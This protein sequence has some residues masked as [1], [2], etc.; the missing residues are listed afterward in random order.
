MLRRSIVRVLVALVPVVSAS[1]FITSTPNFEPPA[2]TAPLLIARDASPPLG[3]VVVLPPTEHITLTASVISQD[4]VPVQVAIYIDYGYQTMPGGTPYYFATPYTTISAA[5]IVDGD[6]PVIV[7][8]PPEIPLAGCHTITIM[9]SHD[10]QTRGGETCPHFITD[11]S[12][13]TWS[14]YFCGSTT[15][16]PPMIDPSVACVPPASKAVECPA[17]FDASTTTSGAAGG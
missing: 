16:C 8:W 5:S 4:T 13:L 9:A 7:D 3:Q 10:F 12:L 15:P 11:S 1:C 17:T 2:Q 14:F 6:R